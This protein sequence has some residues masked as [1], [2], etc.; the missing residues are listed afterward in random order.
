[1]SPDTGDQGF[2]A[3]GSFDEDYDP[4][5][6]NGEIRKLLGA[7]SRSSYVGYTATPFANIMI[8][9]ERSAEDYGA[10][11]FPSTFILSL[12]APDDYFGPL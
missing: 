2:L 11:L 9:D 12:S 1:A 3:D 8:H 7:F 4:K 5:R 10:D 6:I